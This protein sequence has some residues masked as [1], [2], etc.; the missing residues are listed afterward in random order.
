ML[1]PAGLGRYFYNFYSILCKKRQLNC[2]DSQNIRGNPCIPPSVSPP[3][4]S[5]HA[6]NVKSNF[7]LWGADSVS[8]PVSRHLRT[9]G[10]GIHGYPL[11]EGDVWKTGWKIGLL[12]GTL[13]AGAA[14]RRTIL[15][16]WRGRS[17]NFRSYLLLALKN[18]VMTSKPVV[19]AKWRHYW[20]WRH[21][22]E[23]HIK[24]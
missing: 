22:P 8:P 6:I 15:G 23:A 20:K 13:S 11:M 7:G 9:R 24:R 17:E 18:Y 5:R 2:W 19:G 4:V 14:K 1:T 3:L 16:V 12:G 21:F 10:G